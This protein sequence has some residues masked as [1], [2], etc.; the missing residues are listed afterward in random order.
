MLVIKNAYE[1]TTKVITRL[2][3]VTYTGFLPVTSPNPTIETV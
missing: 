1:T 3:Y 2:T